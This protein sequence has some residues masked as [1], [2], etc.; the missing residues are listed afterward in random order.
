M[1]ADRVDVEPVEQ[2]P[3]ICHLV[4]ATEWR[5]GT[6]RPASL[7]A[8]GFVH[9]STV[10][11]ILGTANLFYAGRTDLLVLLVDP[12]AL[13]DLRWEAPSAGPDGA[14]APT[15]RFPHSYTALPAD[16]IVAVHPFPPGP[17][18]RFTTLPPE[19][20]AY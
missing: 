13:P 1:S 9:L 16:A 6:Y 18:G 7:D 14:A 3:V 8:E 11:Q 2:N 17:D 19:L 12:A 4:G 20:V 15:G 10:A 5:S